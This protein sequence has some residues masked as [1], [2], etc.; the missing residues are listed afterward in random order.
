[1]GFTKEELLARLKELQID[2]SQYE[3]PTVLTVEEQAKYVGDKGGGLSKN[4][5]LKDK[6][7]RFY[8]VSALADTKVDMKGEFF[9][10]VL[11]FCIVKLKLD[12]KLG[13]G[14][15]G[16]RM[17]PEEALGEILQV[18]AWTVLES[19]S[20]IKISHFHF[21]VTDITYCLL[22]FDG[23]SLSD[24]LVFSVFKVPLGCVTPFALVNESARHVALLLDKGFQ[25]QE[26]CFFH[27]LSNDMSIALNACDLDKFLKSIERDPS[28]VDLEANPTVGKDQPP[29]LAAF[30]PSGSSIQPDQPDKA[31]P[32]QDP[33]K[34]SVP[35]NKK[36][37]AA[38]GKVA[39]PHASTQN[40]KE[41]PVNPVHQPSVFS[42]AGFFVEEIL[43]KT[44]AL[45][46]SEI[47]EG[48]VKENGVNLGTVVAEN[49]RK[50]LNSDL[51]SM[52]TMFK[53]TAYTQGFH[54][55]A[56]RNL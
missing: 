56:H 17:A 24:L 37:V 26:H 47:T 50:R 33:T 34:N 40:S 31:A 20:L 49:I 4:L 30:V 9:F 35:V 39:K 28:Y 11:T 54:A 48:A 22:K 13:L 6:K 8:I 38:T 1:M 2:F 18:Y 3:H 32:L 19:L 52:A 16:I 42:D 14:K 7:S 10:L 53:N 36:S 43:N 46:L 41:K 55:G 29:D 12:W 21:I 25:S 5:F 27:P 15:G 23:N 51:Q 45:L 44:S